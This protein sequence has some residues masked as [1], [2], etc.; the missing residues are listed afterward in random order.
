MK[1]LITTV[2]GLWLAINVSACSSTKE[3]TQ[4]EL[5]AERNHDIT[6]QTKDGRTIIYHKGE[7]KIT[8]ADGGSI[9]G[10]G[11]LLVNKS[12]NE[13]RDLESAVAFTKIHTINDTEM[14]AIG[15]IGLATTFSIVAVLGALLIALGRGGSW[16]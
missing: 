2:A 4:E 6:V 12:K 15:K 14:T 11:R 10:K 8:D 3:F 16:N 1:R 13:Y 9:E 5:R 7:Y